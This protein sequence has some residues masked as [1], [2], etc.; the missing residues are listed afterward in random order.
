MRS[1]ILIDQFVNILSKP[2]RIDSWRAGERGQQ[3]RNWHRLVAP[4]GHELPNGN[5]V[6]GD[7]VG[8]AAVE[9]AHYC[10]AFIPK[11]PLGD[12]LSHAISVARVRRHPLLLEPDPPTDYG[13]VG[14]ALPEGTAHRTD[15]YPV[16]ALKG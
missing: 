3:H 10:A 4:D 12:H 8:L 2:G 11:R 9:A 13:W 14:F 7:D 6:A 15:A 1:R 5:T 16:G